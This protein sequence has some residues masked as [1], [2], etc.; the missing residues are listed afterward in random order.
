M[1]LI[2]LTVREKLKQIILE[3]ENGWEWLDMCEFK[4]RYIFPM[5]NVNFDDVTPC[6]DEYCSAC[7]AM[8]II[9]LDEEITKTASDDDIDL[10]N[11]G[12]YHAIKGD[13]KK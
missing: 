10:L 3:K 7:Q 12:F 6:T 9:S 4:Q 8:F 5:F 11:S 1:E 2:P 13:D